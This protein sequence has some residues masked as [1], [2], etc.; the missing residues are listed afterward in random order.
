MISLSIA[1]TCRKKRIQK[2]SKKP[3]YNQPT[4][5]KAKA[6]TPKKASKDKQASKTKCYKHQKIGYYTNKY[7]IKKKLNK[8]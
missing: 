4:N 2:E 7:T 1:L 8:F 6:S 5:Q 3:I